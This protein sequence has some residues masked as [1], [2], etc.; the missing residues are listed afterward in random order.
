VEHGVAAW[1]V[2]GQAFG[3]TGV[4]LESFADAFEHGERVA[5]RRVFG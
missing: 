1:R 3:M 4:E 2:E 5:A